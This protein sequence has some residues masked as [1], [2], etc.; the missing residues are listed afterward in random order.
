[1]KCRCQLEAWV[2]C[3]SCGT[4][5]CVV[6]C[7]SWY[8]PSCSEDCEIRPPCEECRVEWADGRCEVCRKAI[9][10]DCAIGT[11]EG[12]GQ[13]SFSFIPICSHD[14]LCVAQ[15]ERALARRLPIEKEELQGKKR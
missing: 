9:C 11:E 8:T 5:I 6:C 15:A 7:R 2:T 1:M 3:F 14:C 10:Q 4:P 13:R 12:Q